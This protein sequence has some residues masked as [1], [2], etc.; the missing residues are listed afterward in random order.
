M[1][2][3]IQVFPNISADFNLPN[4]QCS[5]AAIFIDNTSMHADQYSWDLGNGIQSIDVNPTVTYINN[6]DTA[7]TYNIGL[8]ATSNYGCSAMAYHEFTVYPNPNADFELSENAS[9]APAAISIANYSTGV[10]QYNWN[11]GDGTFSQESANIHSHTYFSN[12]NGNTDYTIR[13]NVSNSFGCI[14]TAS[15]TLIVYPQVIAAFASSPSGC[16]PFPAAMINQSTG[17]VSFEWTFGDG[18]GSV[19]NNP[20]HTYT[21]N[22]TDDANYTIRLIAQ[23]TFGCADTFERPI[24]IFHTPIA[25]AQ[26]DTS[27]GCYPRMVTF[28]NGSIG[29]D[30]YQWVYG[31]GTTSNTSDTLHTVTFFNFGTTQVTYNVM[32]TALTANGCQSQDN[33]NIEVSPPINAAFSAPTQGCSPLT[34]TMDNQSTG[35]FS[36]MWNFGD[37]SISN[38]AEPQHTFVNS[39]LTDTTYTVTLI[40]L[41]QF[42]CSDTISRNISVYHAPIAIAAVDTTIG[43]YPKTVTFYN[44][45]IGADS[46]QWVYGNGSVS[47]T[48]DLF[49]TITYY[50]TSTVLANYNVALTAYTSNG[51]QSQSNLTIDVS[52]PITAAFANLGQGCSPLAVNFDNTS[53]GANTYNWD[54]GDGS[55]SNAFEPMYA[56]SNTT[57]YDTTFTVTLI[58][59]NQFGCS[60]TTTRPITVFHAPNAIAAIDTT[61]GCYPKTVTF[62]NGSTGADSY[63][64][65]YGTGTVSNTA[66]TYHSVTYFNFG[67]TPTTYNVVLNAFTNTGCQSQANLTVNVSPP[68]AA[69]FDFQGQGCSPLSVYFDNQSDGGFTYHWDF[70]DGDISSLQEPQ[71]NFFNYGTSDTTYHVV[72]VVQNQFG[73]SDTTDA[74]IVVYARPYAN[75]EATPDL[76]IWPDATIQ[77]TNTST[78]TSLNYEWNMGNGSTLYVENP[79]SYT[80]NNW[81]EYTL[82][83]IVSNGTCSDTAFQEI[84][85]LPP[86]PVADFEGPAE[87][88]APLTVQF[89][90]N[91]EN[92]VMSMW[93]FGDG[94]QANAT[95]PVYTY[96]QPGTY[97][98]TLTVTGYDGSTDVMTREQIIRVYPSAVAAFTVTP[99]EV[100]VPDQPVYCLNLSSNATIYNWDFGDGSTSTEVNPLYYYTEE[101]VFDVMLIAN[102]QYNCPDTMLVVD[103]VHA[104]AGGLIDFPNAFTPN[105]GGGN[106]GI[107]DPMG[108]ENDVFFPMHAGV[109]EYVLQIFN[110]WGEL[111]FESKDVNRGW[112]GYYRGQLCKQDVYVWKV[113]ARLIDGQIYEKAGDVTLLIK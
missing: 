27:L 107:Y 23:N 88:C 83:L 100:N 20:N 4:P 26:V 25:I 66:D 22:N 5:P 97:T 33:L 70:G 51:C 111:L 9:C 37:G 105:L 13:L 91:S 21:T 36:Y 65:V 31:T 41:N 44:G 38:E 56:F 10:T 62:F 3:P 79:G 106:G 92:A 1:T 40:V 67:N 89:T 80:Y 45:S 74:N 101:G 53:V 52:P 7:V 46:Y 96:W 49:H 85:I 42:G 69:D 108:F 29:A 28:Y 47:N 35:A 24:T 103:A 99:N 112:D 11:Y 63:Q 68:I 48:S 72:L 90:S 86:A 12:G 32:L 60:D 76:Q 87:G 39:G 17:A 15:R 110:K 94:G 50:N 104:K 81:G 30:S 16:S 18:S 73:C 61:I 59:E 78:G 34:A 93:Q 58:V 84:T 43:C 102:N 82:R 77:T 6:T 64:W 57:L 55:T 75:F 98:V 95:N 54:F 109:D 19:E 2:L 14:D 113:K 71:H 8:Q